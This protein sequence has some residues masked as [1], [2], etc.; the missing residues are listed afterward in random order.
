MF[1]TKEVK[2]DLLFW[3]IFLG[4][5]I[6]P[7]SAS[8]FDTSFAY[9][10]IGVSLIYWSLLVFR[11]KLYLGRLFQFIVIPVAASIFFHCL[12]NLQLP[13]PQQYVGIYIVISS[14]CFGSV[15]A[16][17]LFL[18]IQKKSTRSSRSLLSLLVILFVLGILSFSLNL[19][20]ALTSKSKAFLFFGE[21]SHFF[22]ALIPYISF[23]IRRTS[24][25]ISISVFASC[26]LL[27]ILSQSIIGVVLSFL[28]FLPRAIL[29]SNRR[30]LV[31]SSCLLA[32][33]IL[34][35]FSL[36]ASSFPF[37]N[38]LATVNIT[39]SSYYYGWDSIIASLIRFG[40]LGSGF[41]LMGSSQESL[42]SQTE[43]FN[44]L[45]LLNSLDGIEDGTFSFSRLVVELGVFSMP[46]IYLVT[47][48]IFLSIQSLKLNPISSDLY[49][50]LFD[51]LFFTTSVSLTILVYLF[52]RCPGGLISPLTFYISLNHLLLRR[53][54]SRR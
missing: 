2:L 38:K 1:F 28:A 32:M 35:A 50:N 16:D 13:N 15:C 7:W 23:V 30:L 26:I 25:G 49:P 10:L 3:C 18:V 20:L 42:F 48:D 12:A 22:L 4:S 51:T 31:L 53:L 24:F 45:I 29:M 11:S 6:F 17:K 5:T 46:I 14:I 52:V 8:T 39:V 44:N 27:A 36:I 40:G 47:R 21:I 19:P 34:P 37:F 54:S 33:I 9:L 43:S 41:M